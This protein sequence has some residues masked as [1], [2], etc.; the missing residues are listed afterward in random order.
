MEAID[1]L[2]L[3]GEILSFLGEKMIF[4][5]FELYAMLCEIWSQCTRSCVLVSDHDLLRLE[6]R[7]FGFGCIDGR[8]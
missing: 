7:F 4:S 1:I 5:V 8:G 6:F 3:R 2:A